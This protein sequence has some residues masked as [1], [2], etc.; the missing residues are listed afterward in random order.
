M[1][2]NVTYTK[3]DGSRNTIVLEDYSIEYKFVEA[4][5]KNPG[6]DFAISVEPLD[7]SHPRLN[8]EMRSLLCPAGKFVYEIEAWH[9]DRTLCGGGE[10]YAS[11]V[12]DSNGRPFTFATA[13]DGHKFASLFSENP[14][15]IH[16]INTLEAA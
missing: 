6:H 15:G 12:K 1:K 11:T 3:L 14:K 2:V 8:A 4:K 13:D 9:T 16:N 5:R 7:W 10:I